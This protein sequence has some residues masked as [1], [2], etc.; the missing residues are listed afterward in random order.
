MYDWHVP[1]SIRVW[2]IRLG[3]G[4]FCQRA[5]PRHCALLLLWSWIA[6]CSFV[7]AAN[8]ASFRH[9]VTKNISFAILEDYDKGDDLQ[10]IA[11]DFQLMKELGI[12]VLL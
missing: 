6:A 3:L 8:Q 7:T 12:D 2:R 4:P 1:V 10:E 11:K 5:I 9:G